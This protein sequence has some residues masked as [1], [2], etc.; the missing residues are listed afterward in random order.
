VVEAVTAGEGAIGYADASQAGENEIAKIKVGEEF[1]EP[2][3]EAA[4][5]ILEESPEDKA[6]AADEFMFPFKLDHRTETSGTYPIVLVSYI[7]ACTKY[8]SAGEAEVS[9]PTSNT[10]SAR[11]ARKRRLKTPAPRRSRVR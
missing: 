10:R 7:L 4:A 1:A 9:R 11:K 2:T 8:G 5:K 6:L 3:P